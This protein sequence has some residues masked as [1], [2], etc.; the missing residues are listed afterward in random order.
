VVQRFAGLEHISATAKLQGTGEE[1]N[2]LSSHPQLEGLML[3]TDRSGSA[4]LRSSE[5]QV[6]RL[7]NDIFME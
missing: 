1:L 7:D 6:D 2:G 5:D 3:T 4:I